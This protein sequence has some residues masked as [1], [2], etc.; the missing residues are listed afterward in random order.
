M[1]DKD[2]VEKYFFPVRWVPY[3]E[4]GQL[5]RDEE[6]KALWEPNELDR[7]KLAEFEKFV[8]SRPECHGAK[9][10]D[11]ARLGFGCMK[12]IHPDFEW[13]GVSFSLTFPFFC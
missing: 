1:G 7:I 6:N 9:L 10:P 4:E 13:R 12:D 8:A 5:K 2:T 11:V 3:R